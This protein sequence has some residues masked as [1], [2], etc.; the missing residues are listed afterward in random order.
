MYDKDKENLLQEL[1][2]TYEFL[3]SE[4]TCVSASSTSSFEH[5]F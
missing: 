4:K 2:T 5:S 1:W 3:M